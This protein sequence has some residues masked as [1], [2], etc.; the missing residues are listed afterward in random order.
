MDW[1]EPASRFGF[2]IEHDLFGKQCH[3]RVIAGLAGP[4]HARAQELEKAAMSPPSLYLRRGSPVLAKVLAPFRALALSVLLTAFAL[5][6][7]AGPFEDA[8]AKFATDDFSDTEEAIGAVAASG[9]PL[10]YP[11]I[12]ALQGERL[13]FDAGSGK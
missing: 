6:A 7:F 2:L 5:P 11:I 9:S 3:L 1:V 8:V 13:M 10:A 4:D 12:S